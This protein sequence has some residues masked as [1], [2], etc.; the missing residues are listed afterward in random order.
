MCFSNT[1]REGDVVA[2]VS[3]YIQMDNQGRI[4]IEVQDLENPDILE[5][6]NILAVHYA[7]RGAQGD[8]GAVEILYQSQNN[9][10]VLYGNYGYGNLDLDAVIRKLPMLS[11]LDSRYTLSPPYP[12]GGNLDIPNGWRYG[13][14]GALNHFF[15]REEFIDRVEPFVNAFLKQGGQR[16]QMFEAVAWFCGAV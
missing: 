8:A 16:C 9:I 4:N 11:C 2:L 13:Y 15:V 1:V 14:M 6:N 10:R 3:E 7:D 5:E 12:F